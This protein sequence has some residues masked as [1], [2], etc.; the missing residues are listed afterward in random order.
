MEE[1]N[2]AGGILGREVRISGKDP[3]S[4]PAGFQAEAERLVRAEKAKALFRCYMSSTRKA[5]VNR[6]ATLPP[7]RRPILPPL[8]AVCAGA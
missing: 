8:D 6:L 2:R 5:T 4:I 3:K 1:I 7:Y